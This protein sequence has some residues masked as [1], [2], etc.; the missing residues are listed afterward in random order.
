MWGINT[1]NIHIVYNAFVAPEIKENKEKLKDK[2][3]FSYPTIVSVG[4]LVPWKGFSTLIEAFSEIKKNYEE[5]GLVIIDD[6]PEKDFL[7][8]KVKSLNLE[9]AVRFIGKIPQKELYEYI[10]AADIF[11]LL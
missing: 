1:E 3:N 11:A 9:G 2:L 7:K 8:N 4:R 5:A 6:G 10:K